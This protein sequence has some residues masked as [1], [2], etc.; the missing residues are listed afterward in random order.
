[1]SIE[2]VMNFKIKDKVKIDFKIDKAYAFS[3]NGK[4]ISSP[5]S[6]KNV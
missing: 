6:S 4:L 5:F 3:A 2:E 1:M